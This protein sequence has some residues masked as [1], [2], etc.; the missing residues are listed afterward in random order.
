MN[1]YRIVW[2][3]TPK[4]REV[5]LFVEYTLSTD[6]VQIDAIR[7]TKV[8][9]LDAETK[10]PIR[11]VGVHTDMGRKILTEAYL[12]DRSTETAL[13]DEIHSHVIVREDSTVPQIAV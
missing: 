3:D 8:T 10:Q 1:G 6:S 12:A 11:S 13:E 9:F 5:E 4:M 2:E 7:P